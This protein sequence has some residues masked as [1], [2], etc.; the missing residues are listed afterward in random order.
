MRWRGP[1]AAS[2][3]V[4]RDGECASAVA[5][6]VRPRRLVVLIAIA[7]AVLGYTQG[8]DLET[9][10]S[11]SGMLMSASGSASGSGMLMGGTDDIVCGAADADCVRCVDAITETTALDDAP[12]ESELI[13][14][15]KCHIECL[16]K[17]EPLK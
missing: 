14:E 2:L 1:V 15:G 9:A 6:Q 3:P 7:L 17:V 16:N 8:Q 13:A 5:G 10:A 4:R 12:S 11:G